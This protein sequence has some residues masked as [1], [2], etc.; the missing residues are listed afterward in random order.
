MNNYDEY[1]QIGI[2]VKAQGIKGELRVLPTTDEPERFGLLSV[3]TVDKNGHAE[4]EVQSARVQKNI[5]VL[6]LK[7]IDDRNTAEMLTGAAIKIPPEKA[8]PLEENEYY[9][10]DLIGLEVFTEEGEDLGR[11]SDVIVTGANDVYTVKK[12]GQKEILIPAIKD[13]VLK[14]DIPGGRMTV[15]L[16]DGLR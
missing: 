10:R 9:L 8:L 12:P 7:G 2:I 5:I 15:H 13:C 6:K 1:F 16:L 3:V 14:V 11:L 4:Y